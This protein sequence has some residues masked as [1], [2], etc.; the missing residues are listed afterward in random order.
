MIILVWSS[1][2]KIDSKK[3]ALI[4]FKTIFYDKNV[5]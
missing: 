4:D 3:K 2:S 1:S 5:T